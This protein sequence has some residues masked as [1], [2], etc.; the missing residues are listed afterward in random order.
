MTGQWGDGLKN[1]HCAPNT[2]MWPGLQLIPPPVLAVGS[3]PLYY[4]V[5]S[6]L[7][8]TTKDPISQAF[9]ES[10]YPGQ[11]RLQCYVSDLGVH[12]HWHGLK[13]ASSGLITPINISTL[14]SK[15][16]IC[17]S[18]VWSSPPLLVPVN[19]GRTSAHAIQ[20][21]MFCM[22]GPLR[23]CK[24]FVR[25]PRGLKI[26]LKQWLR[27]YFPPQGLR[28][29]DHKWSNLHARLTSLNSEKVQCFFPHGDL[30]FKTN[31]NN[32]QQLWSQLWSKKLQILP[33]STFSIMWLFDCWLNVLIVYWLNNN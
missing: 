24:L 4:T 9:S 15:V 19:R 23:N 12:L 2:L 14:R 10:I 28:K 31:R 29:P 1:T 22:Q 18:D 20:P 33:G 16:S 6:V 25:W 26:A 5:R 3:R 8:Q 30:Q 11:R 7:C 17:K 13:A 27:I 32:Q 21:R